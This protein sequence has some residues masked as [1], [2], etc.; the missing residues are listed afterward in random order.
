M[1]PKSKD[2]KLY[3]KPVP[4]KTFGDL[5][6]VWLTIDEIKAYQKNG[7]IRAKKW[8]IKR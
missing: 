3:V 6:F 2:L 1:K 4:G 7:W 5:E 8:K